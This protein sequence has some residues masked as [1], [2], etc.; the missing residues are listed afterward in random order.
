MQHLKNYLYFLLS[1]TLLFLACKPKEQECYQPLNTSVKA[2]FMTREIRDSIIVTDTSTRDTTIYLR[3]DTGLIAPVFYSVDETPAIM[4]PGPKG[5][6]VI[7][8]PL[9]PDKENMR[10][11]LKADSNLAI[12]DTLTI[13]YT[14]T[15]KFINNDCGFTNYFKIV[16]FNCTNNIFDSVALQTPEVTNVGSDRHLLLYIF[17]K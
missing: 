17:K 5:T 8:F 12:T 6:T 9:N 11:L 14:S 3:R 16:G 2:A 7:A 13:Q 15:L 1:I 4:I 10:Y